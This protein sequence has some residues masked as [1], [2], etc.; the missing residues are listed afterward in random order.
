M[1]LAVVVVD[2]EGAVII[3]AVVTD[4]Q[5]VVVV[6]VAVEASETAATTAAFPTSGT[7]SGQK[8]RK[9]CT[10]FISVFFSE[11]FLSHWWKFSSNTAMA[12]ST[13]SFIKPM[14]QREFT[15]L[16]FNK[17]SVRESKRLANEDA[18]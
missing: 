18:S 9:G 8:R 5:D 4:S 16:D 12:L 7:H 10:G 11:Q 6:D 15:G 2:V 1:E 14:T 17:V 3:G 13:L